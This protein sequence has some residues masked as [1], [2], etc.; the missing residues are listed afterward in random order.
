MIPDHNVCYPGN[1]LLRVVCW[2]KG[3]VIKALGTEWHY[4]GSGTEKHECERCGNRYHKC[5]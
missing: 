2:F 3:H 4:D 1:P 5:H